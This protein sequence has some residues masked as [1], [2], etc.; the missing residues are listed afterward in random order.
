MNNDITCGRRHFIK[1]GATSLVAIPLLVLS[2]SAAA[3]VNAA[4]RSAMNYQ[5]QP[6]GN[7]SCSGCVQFDTG[8][9]SSAM[10]SCK[11]FPGDT[12]IS[13]NGYC[14]AWAAKAS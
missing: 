14:N 9:S 11:L 8:T 4:A 6:S 13:P 1:I 10:G 2:G 5:N 12:E 3:S 7:K